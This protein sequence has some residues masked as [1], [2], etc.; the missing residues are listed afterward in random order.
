MKNFI[1]RTVSGLA[2]IIIMI[3]GILWGVLPYAVIM[4]LIIAAMMN[5]YMNLGLG[6]GHVLHKTLAIISGIS[7]FIASIIVLLYDVSAMYLTVPLL[8]LLGIFILNL[9]IKEFNIHESETNSEGTAIRKANGYEVFPFAIT[10]FIYI[11]LPFSMCNIIALH[12]GSYSGHVLLSMFIILWASDVGAYCT[13]STLG[14]YFGKKLFP[15]ISPKKSWMGFWGGL[16]CSVIAAIILQYVELLK[17][18]LCDAVVLA[19]IICTFGV[20]GD[21]AESQLKRNFGVKD[22]GSIMPG[23]GGM[24]D[25]LDGAL[26]AFP[27]AII[28][29]IFFVLR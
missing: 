10:S 27:V 28:Y 16:L 2:F 20:W 21:L 8:P 14:R 5:E 9:Y 13:G 15:S 25:R 4:S 1:L 11:A 23:H 29:L 17:I 3:G 6:K 19:I 12:S 18:N 7:F 24:L 22:S 26:L